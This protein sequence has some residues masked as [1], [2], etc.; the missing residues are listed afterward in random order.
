MP[1]PHRD[2]TVP[3][4]LE[5]GFYTAVAVLA[6]LPALV[7]GEHVVGDGVDLFGT[8]WFYWWIQDCIVTMADPGFTD[9][10]FHPLG[11]DIF[12]HTGNNFLDAG[13][14]VPFQWIFRFPRYQPIFVAFVMLGNALTFRPLAARFAGA[15]GD[16]SWWQL[17]LGRGQLTVAAF[18]ATGLWMASSYVLF[19]ITA[20]RLTQ[21]FL[22]FLPLALDRLL[23]LEGAAPRRSDAMLA[24]L[25]TAL[26][27][28]DYWYM[29]HFQALLWIWIG[30]WAMARNPARLRLLAHYALAAISALLVVSPFVVAM[31]L[32][33]RADAVPGL[34]GQG[35]LFAPPQ[36]LG[37]NVA[38]QL[39]GYWMMERYGA[40][41]LGYATW[42]GALVLILLSGR[43]RGRWL[44]AVLL[45]LVFAVGPAWPTGG[46]ASITWYPYLLA[47]NTV[48]FLDRL[49]FPYRAV[50]MV[51]L[52]VCL[53]VAAALPPWLRRLSRVR[54]RPLASA[55]PLGLALLL[56]GIN[57]AEQH[58]QLC[59]PFVTRDAS[60]PA[61]YRWIGQEGG[62]I[63]HLPFGVN[64]SAIVWQTIHGQPIFGGMGENAPLLWPEGFDKKLANPLIRF[65]RMSTRRP[66][67]ATAPSGERGLELLREDGFRWVILHRDLVESENLERL[68][69][70]DTGRLLARDYLS[71]EALERLPFEASE[72]I[73]EL[74]GPPLAV[75]GPLVIWDLSGEGAAPSG[76]EA[77]A[78][79]LAERNWESE[80]PPAYEKLLESQGRL[81]GKE[82]ATRD[83]SPG[84]R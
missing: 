40:P 36:A 34:S 72:R 62:A 71:R 1:S 6:V 61:A 31:L 57:L 14:S 41:M 3:R 37:N 60:P 70:S 4:W 25:F 56:L 82:W 43:D 35:G 20:G 23:A 67:A 77:N 8:L 15:V 55:G 2:P 81:P 79:R 39:H 58:S 45:L 11:K 7:R 68:P 19:E 80:A 44:L 17:A 69:P 46:G 22:W 29:G 24:G 33:V 59:W 52:V 13:L 74:L 76:L 64:Q 65:L 18:V 53:G 5:L 12:A 63:V 66:E 73:A 51:F 48:P 28:I 47:Y 30:A 50:V 10:F 84:G 21:A 9:M 54:W 38:T 27:A 78:A 49:W 75:E 83:H 16:R 42:I 32:E 26:Q